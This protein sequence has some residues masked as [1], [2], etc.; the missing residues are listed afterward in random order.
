MFPFQIPLNLLSARHALVLIFHRV[1]ATPN[2]L[3]PWDLSLSEFDRILD[4]FLENF[5]VLPL[6]EVVDGLIRG[7]LPPRAVSLTFDD[8]YPEWTGGLIPLLQRRRCPATFFVNTGPV[9]G[10]A[11]WNERIV[12]AVGSTGRDFV[13]LSEYGL[14]R[15]VLDSPDARRAVVAQ[16]DARLKYRT[17]EERGRLLERLEEALAVDRASASRIDAA[18]VRDLKS[19]GFEVGAHTAHHPILRIEDTV[20]AM[21]EIGSAREQLETIIGDKVRFFAYPNGFPGRD[22]LTEHVSLVQKLGYRAAF[23]T[24]PS[25]V[26]KHSSRWQIPRA[27]P[28]GRSRLRKAFQTTRLYLSGGMSRHA[29]RETPPEGCREETNQL[30]LRRVLMVAFHFPP[31]KGSS[32]LL[33]TLKFVQYLPRYGWQPGVLSAEPIAYPDTSPEHLGEI[34]PE[35]PVHRAWAFDVARHLAFR[36]RYLAF[37]ALPDRWASWIPFGILAGLRFIR[38]W[39]TT[40]VFSTYPIASALIIGYTLH[41]VT[42]LPWVASLRDPLVGPGSSGKGYKKPIHQWIENRL[43]RQAERV[44][45]VTEEAR[46]AFLQRQGEALSWKTAVI[47][48][49]YDE[50]DFRGLPLPMDGASMEAGAG[51]DLVLL[52]SGLIDVETRNPA[53]FITT[54]TRLAPDGQFMGRRLRLVL[55][56]S[57]LTA[58]SMRSLSALAGALCLEWAPPVAYRDALA[59]MSSVHGLLVFQGPQH[60]S[61][62]PAKIYEYCRAGRPI[63]ALVGMHGCTAAFLRRLGSPYVNPIDDESAME[64]GV[65]AFLT[66][67]VTGKANGIDG[68]IARQ[69]SRENRTRELARLFDEVIGGRSG[70]SLQT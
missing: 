8:G 70:R 15:L 36:G 28:W 18:F 50:A 33:R 68:H 2:Q 23:S 25:V 39:K 55:R 17:L 13:D 69:H 56:A 46:S 45:F 53:P 60:D 20:T 65:R 35:V 43:A 24:E 51:T 67:L 54:L 34:P 42:G 61:Q 9:N 44:V 57:N 19:R 6:S 1:S 38:R 11:L 5:R 10:E 31:Q 64:P 32:G 27:L 22:Y 66:D 3:T 14:P 4:F 37:T 30:L 58:S 21:R 62:I 7:K 16:L 49:G 48:N 26:S 41:R 47:E 40:I 12:H 59:E 63:L 52:H 29:V